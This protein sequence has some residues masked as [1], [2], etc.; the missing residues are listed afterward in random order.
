MSEQQT[1][2]RVL[3]WHVCPHCGTGF[4]EDPFASYAQHDCCRHEWQNH[5]SWTDSSG[6]HGSKKCAKCMRYV[7]W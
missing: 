5:Q 4:T 7:Q 3:E 6:E 2:D 1:I